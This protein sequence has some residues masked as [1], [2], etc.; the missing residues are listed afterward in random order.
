MWLP[1]DD[2]RRWWQVYCRFAPEGLRKLTRIR[3]IAV[4]VCAPGCWMCI[5]VWGATVP[6]TSLLLLLS[7]LTAPFLRR[8]LFP[9]DATVVAGR[10]Q[11][12]VARRALSQSRKDS[13]VTPSILA[14]LTLCY[15][16]TWQSPLCWH[17]FC[18]SSFSATPPERMTYRSNA[19]GRH[20]LNFYTPHIEERK[21]RHPHTD[22]YV[23]THLNTH[24]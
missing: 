5:T 24:G 23:W 7:L 2:A 16:N 3:G 6:S 17:R 20:K 21:E 19:L 15:R 9:D 10:L 12:N 4:F 1:L 18:L 11:H 8:C 22:T 14:R 13:L